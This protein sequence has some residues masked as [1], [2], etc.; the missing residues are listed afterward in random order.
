[1]ILSMP[2]LASNLVGKTINGWIVEEKLSKHDGT[3]GC[4]SSGYRVRDADGRRAFLKAMNIGYA[5]HNTGSKSFVDSMQE[6]TKSFQHEE[7][8]VRLCGEKRHDRIVAGIDSGE[9]KEATSPMDVVPYLVFE[10]AEHGDLRRHPKMKE[11]DLAWRLTVFHGVCVGLMQLHSSG[12]KHQDLKPSNILMFSGDTSK[13]GDLGRATTGTGMYSEPQHW[14][15]NSYVPVE[16]YYGHAETD[17][18]AQKRGADFYMLGGILAYIVSDAHIYGLV[19]GRIPESFRP[20]KMPG[21]FQQALPAIRSAT[22]EAITE[23]TAT[24]PTHIREELSQMLKWLCEPD[25]KRR[26]HPKTLSEFGNRFSLERVVS[27]ADRIAKKAR[28][29]FK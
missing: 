7:A 16:F 13:I 19:I 25:P 14:G 8:L 21:G 11:Q 10:L 18:E 9:Y 2:N 26:G 22:F 5:F 24:V 12:V 23:I 3:G 27:I 20:G 28:I 4:F 1:M 15:G 6:M 17:Q 29:A